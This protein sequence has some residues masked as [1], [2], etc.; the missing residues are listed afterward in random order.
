MFDREIKFNRFLLGYFDQVVADIPADQICERAP[1]GGHPP[2]WVLG[3]LAIVAEMGQSLLGG[4][5]QHPDWVAVFGPGSSDE[6]I[7]AGVFAKDEFVAQIQREYPKLCEMLQVAQSSNLEQSHGV[8]LLDGTPIE[9][10]ADM[11][12]HLLTTHFSFHLAQLSGWRR[13]AG[14]GPVI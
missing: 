8:Q 1:G 12:A 13:A 10:V 7:D 2:L 11:E 4:Q 6:V 9:T 3:H 14:K 5:M